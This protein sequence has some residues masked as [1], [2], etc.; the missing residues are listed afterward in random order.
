LEGGDLAGSAVD[1]ALGEHGAG[2]VV[3]RG[4][5]VD[6]AAVAAGAERG[7]DWLGSLGGPFGDRGHR[8]G[9]GKHRGGGHGQDG[10]ERVAAATKGTRVGDAAR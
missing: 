6:L 10:D 1:L 3:H 5:Q 8:A 4:Q 2:G 9:T 7:T